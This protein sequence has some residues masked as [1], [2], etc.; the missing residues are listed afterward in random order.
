M[1][2]N[3]NNND[4]NKVGIPPIE[5]IPTT[6]SNQPNSQQS[7]TTPTGPTPIIPTIINN[8]PTTQQNTPMPQTNPI[9]SNQVNNSTSNI[10]SMHGM[11]IPDLNGTSS[12]FDIGITPE[13]TPQTQN[14]PQPTLT[15]TMPQM[16]ST[17]Q[18][19]NSQAVASNQ[20]LKT[21]TPT[22][23]NTP[24]NEEQ[25]INIG[26][27]QLP[28]ESE[29]VAVSKYLKYMILFGLPGIGTIILI[30]TIF[31][32]NDPS[33]SNYAKATLLYAI[34]LSVIFILLWVLVISAVIGSGN[35]VMPINS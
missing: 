15:P 5:P 34:I 27:K 28:K 17:T 29:V 31:K 25:D 19:N 20:P 14:S 2:N 30:V 10:N 24:Q 33:I 9:N 32:K 13:P 6:T 12:P 4:A 18:T 22:S 8:Q 26:V 1:N 16:A 11:Q 23:T 7:S 35:S 3:L 21:I